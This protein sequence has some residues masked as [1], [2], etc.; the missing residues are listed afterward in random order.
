VTK[1]VF[2][3]AVRDRV[4]NLGYLPGTALENSVVL[5]LARA[6]A[7]VARQQYRAGK[8]RLDFAWPER[9]IVLEADGWW[10][11]SPEGAAKD[12]IRDSWLRSQG[13]VV[14]R[15]DDEHGGDLLDAQVRRVAQLVARAPEVPQPPPP[16]RRDGCAATVWDYGF[17]GL[18]RPCKNKRR[19]GS[20][21]CGSHGG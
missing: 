17:E 7:P 9:K 3:Q 15:V 6:G 14:F 19:P 1:T 11:R 10:H 16:R 18:K 21:H 4:T 8:F 2:S 20:E 5:A 13:W 12:R